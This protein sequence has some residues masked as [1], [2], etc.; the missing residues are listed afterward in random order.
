LQFRALRPRIISEALHLRPIFF[1]F[2]L[3]YLIGP[4]FDSLFN[5]RPDPLFQTCFETSA[6]V[7]RMVFV[8]DEKVAA[9]RKYTQFKKRVQ[10]HPLFETKWSK[11]TPYFCMIQIMMAKKPHPLGLH[12]HIEPLSWSTPR[13]SGEGGG[14]EMYS[15]HVL[16]YSSSTPDKFLSLKRT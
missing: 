4:D 13:E 9:A 8:N 12:K 1:R 15:V 6:P 10:N 7:K 11:L 14:G 16:L 2:S 5:L 3:P